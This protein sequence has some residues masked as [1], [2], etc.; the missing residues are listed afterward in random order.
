MLSTTAQPKALMDIDN[1]Q[2]LISHQVSSITLSFCWY[3]VG[4]LK[5]VGKQLWNIW[6]GIFILKS[7]FKNILDFKSMI[8]KK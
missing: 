5:S 3:Q 1:A 7:L 2:S 6:A 8:I 4:L